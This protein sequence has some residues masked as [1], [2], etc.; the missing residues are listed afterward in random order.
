MFFEPESNFCSNLRFFIGDP[1]RLVFSIRPR[2]KQRHRMISAWLRV[3]VRALVMRHSGACWR[4]LGLK[5]TEEASSHPPCKAQLPRPRFDTVLRKLAFRRFHGIPHKAILVS[6]PHS[7]DS[8]LTTRRSS[9][10]WHG[11]SFCGFPYRKLNSSNLAVF[12]IFTRPPGNGNW[13]SHL[14]VDKVPMAALA[15][16]VHNACP[17]KLGNEFSHFGW[18]SLVLCLSTT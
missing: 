12:C 9:R 16:S 6:C 5:L 18:H 7:T 13:P 3:R 10:I 8:P 17:F 4:S 1:P 15:S 11:L 2:P 14:W